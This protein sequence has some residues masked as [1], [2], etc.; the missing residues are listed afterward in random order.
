MPHFSKIAFLEKGSVRIELQEMLG[1]SWVLKPLGRIAGL[2]HLS[3]A[4]ED[5]AGEVKRWSA[6]GMKLL[7]PPKFAGIKIPAEEDWWFAYFQ[8]P[9]G[10]SIELRGPWK[11]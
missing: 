2:Y 6:A 8:G 5:L 3:F 1:D 9:D 7:I 10:E 4:V 11:D